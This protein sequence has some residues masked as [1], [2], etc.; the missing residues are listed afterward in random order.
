MTTDSDATAT[1]AA[2]AASSAASAASAAPAA[3]A[4]HRRTREATDRKIVQA[5]L[6]I[7]TTEGIGA[8]TIEKVARASGVAKTTIYRRYRDTDDLLESISTLDIVR[9]PHVEDL[10]PSRA[11]LERLLTRLAQR[12]DEGIGVKAVGLVLSS[13]NAFFRRIFDQGIPPLERHLSEFFLRGEREGVFRPGLDVR[14]LFDTIIGSMIA[15]R[16]ISAAEARR[17]D[18]GREGRNKAG[19]AGDGAETEDTG[20]SERDAAAADVGTVAEI[21]SDAP[22]ATTISDTSDT[23]DISSATDALDWARRMADLLWPAIAAR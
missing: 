1:P 16:A 13:D 11:N 7:A 12:F 9:S 14:L 8:V 4:R 2:P 22:R 17:A 21:A 18:R 15:D 23:A 5:V 6:G 20:V 19:G 10:P 3:S